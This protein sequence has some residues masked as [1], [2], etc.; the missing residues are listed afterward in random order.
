MK[1]LLIIIPVFNQLFYTKQVIESIRREREESTEIDNLYL[2]IVDNNSQDE[3]LSYLQT[4]Y[5]V[6]EEE[7]QKNS[8]YFPFYI[9]SE[10]NLGYGGGVNLCLEKYYF[11]IHT[12]LGDSL[13][14]LIMNNDMLLLKGCLD[15]LVKTAYSKDDIGIVG[16]KLLF[17]DGSIQHAGAFLNAFGW[18]QHIGGGQRDEVFHDV[19]R[20]MEYVTGALFYVKE[21][22]YRK[23]RLFD[24]RFER[25]YFEEVDYCYRAREKGYKTW[26]TPHSKAIH[27][28][29]ITSKSMEGD[30]EK[31]K[32]NI[33]DKNQIKFYLKRDEEK[34]E[35]VRVKEDSGDHKLLITSQIY[36]EW[37]FT[38][39][40]RNLAKGLM[41]NGVDVSIAPVEYHYD[42]LNMVDWEIKQMINKPN[43]YWNRSVLRSCEGDH[44]YLMPPGKQ[45]IGHTT[46]ESNRIPH[47]WK[48]QLN[49]VDKVLTTSSFFRNVMLENGVKTP[50]FVLPNSVNLDYYKKEGE[51]LHIPS[52][53]LR[54]LNFVSIFHFGERKA[55]D[56]L[57]RAF[58]KAFTNKDDVSLTLHALSMKHILQQQNT[59]IDEWIKN[60]T[61][62]ITDRPPI[63]VTS[64]YL[65]DRLMPNFLRNFDVFVLPSRGEGFGLPFI[66]AGAVGIPSIATGY[67]GLLD[68]VGEDNG[69][70]IDYELTDIPL[71]YL[72][73]FQNYIGGKWAEP[74]EN[75][76][77]ELFRQVYNNR[78]EVKKKGQCAYEKA[79]H[80]SME[81]IGRLGKSLIFEE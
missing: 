72:P 42:K 19:G 17:P 24:E 50:I 66:E 3:T 5:G 36:G 68:Y 22:V 81:N 13:D 41:R 30:Q 53:N 12:S 55:P 71:Q 62:G 9:H 70:L 60:V 25:G 74:N 77:I 43:D 15:N 18:G 6:E 49:N 67:S 21:E 31:V 26:Y 14:I 40:M 46:G 29:N 57:V 54:G 1:N 23:V 79:Q 7:V 39:V 65:E 10:V 51:K 48:Q 78:E 27:Y 73:Y 11:D 38:M 76:L 16:G 58:S 45:R 61:H 80:Y 32:K 2:C 47:D 34:E 8:K 37:S 75:H 28:E 33:S 4:E 63:L 56:I 35:E 52:G 59:N 20:E 64:S 69:W 44:M